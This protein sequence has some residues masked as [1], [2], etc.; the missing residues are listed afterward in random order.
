MVLTL[1][2]DEDCAYNVPLPPGITVL[3]RNPAT[4]NT[5]PNVSRSHATV[6]VEGSAVTVTAMGMNAPMLCRPKE[7]AEPDVCKLTKGQKEAMHVGDSIALL[8][9]GKYKYTLVEGTLT[10]TDAPKLERRRSSLVEPQPYEDEAPPSATAVRASMPAEEVKREDGPPTKKAK[11]PTEVPDIRPVCKYG[12]GC[13]RHNRRHFEEYAHPHLPTMASERDMAA[14]CSDEGS[15]SDAAVEVHGPTSGGG[16]GDTLPVCPYGASCYR[17]GPEHR[18]KFAHPKAPVE[19]KHTAAAALPAPPKSSAKAADPGPS[20]KN[21]LADGDVFIMTSGLGQ[22]KIR[23]AGGVY[24]CS[25]VAWR[26]QKRAV[27]ERTCK[28]LVA[29][30][31]EDYM[32]WKQRHAVGAETVALDDAPS[33]SRAPG[34]FSAPGVLLANKWDETMDPTGWWL[35]E[36]LDGVRA[37]WNGTRFLSR[38]GNEFLA[39]PYFTKELPSDVI[40]DGELFSGRKKFQFT[41]GV[42]KSS[43]KAPLWRS[44]TYQVFDVPSLKK[45]FEERI[46]FLEERFG[47]RKGLEFVRVVEHTRCGGIGDLLAKLKVVEREGGEGL[48]LRQPGS[49]YVGVRSNTL[50]KVKSIHD[51]EAKVIAHERGKGKNADRTGAL[52]CILP[53][54]KKF[55]VGSGLTDKDRISPPKLGTIITFRFQELT[56]SGVPRFPRYM[57]VRADA[58]WPPDSPWPP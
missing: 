12:A 3:G 6:E 22:Y 33:P 53:N 38:L 49:M 31:G 4:G 7:G 51:Y 37:Y 21:T 19:S 5:D 45:P 15:D 25:C 2:G 8:Q 11:V 34:K 42:V 13:Y 9:S 36:K 30:L 44:L 14:E 47:E 29:F 28:H 16:V 43:A 48:M 24:Y 35:S 17:T 20:P 18:T 41:V 23:N 55:S 58:K 27:D 56:D 54:G 40:L 39:P 50:L 32:E 26:F 1:V 10:P 57:G 46:T 52:L